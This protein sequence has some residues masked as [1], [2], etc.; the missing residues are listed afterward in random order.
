[1]N[2]K[3]PGT[4]VAASRQEREAI[5]CL[6]SASSSQTTFQTPAKSN[7]WLA[8]GAGASII[9]HNRSTSKL[10]DIHKTLQM[11]RSLIGY[12]L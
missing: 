6:E 1:M 8:M 2:T 10:V 9:G 5:H 12:K 4:K 3:P 7:K 11:Y